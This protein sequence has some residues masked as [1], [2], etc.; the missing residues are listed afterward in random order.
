M[1]AIL[2]LVGLDV[3]SHNNN[4]FDRPVCFGRELKCEQYQRNKRRYTLQFDNR[5]KA[6][7]V[8]FII[9]GGIL[10]GMSIDGDQTILL[11]SINASEN[12]GTED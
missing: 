11:V 4:Q 1:T 2:V 8:L 12:G 5:E 10:D 6:H 3:F 9:R 7:P